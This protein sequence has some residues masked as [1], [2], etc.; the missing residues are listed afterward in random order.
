MKKRLLLP[1]FIC[2]HLVTLS[3]HGAEYEEELTGEQI[4]NEIF[5]EELHRKFLNEIALTKRFED[6]LKEENGQ[7]VLDHGATRTPEKSVFEFIIRLGRA[8]GLAI[9]G[10]Y[11]FPEKKIIAVDLQAPG[12]NAFK[13]F[14]SY[15]DV[16]KFSPKA[17]AAIRD[18]AQRTN[19]Q[20]SR[21]GMKL[22][23]KLEK[24][25]FLTRTEAEYFVNEIVY[26]FFSRQGP[27][28]KESTLKILKKESP[29]A[30]NA[31]LLGPDFNHIAYSL[32]DLAIADW[33]G[34]EVIDTLTARMKAE[35]FSMLPSIQGEVGGVLR[36]TSTL[37]EDKPFEVETPDKQVVTVHQPSKFLEF[38]QRGAEVDE[39]GAVALEHKKIKLFRGF[40]RDN[41][42]KI[43]EST[44]L[45]E[46][47]ENVAMSGDEY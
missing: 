44:G 37:A 38:I 4:W 36:Q 14:S 40:L 9:H 10:R 23:G 30:V 27:P 42:S 35:G 13:W 21:Q 47:P 34:V 22:L 18:D 41:A 26:R 31:L 12:R 24:E 15:I 43:Y 5:V 8:F 16:D 19:N 33:Y 11:D 20:M 3:L 32:N 7:V 2:I 6:M 46:E 25:G 1:L 17:A 45:V 29:E 28:L 39:N